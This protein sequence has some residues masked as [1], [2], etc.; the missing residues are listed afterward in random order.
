MNDNGVPIRI[1]TA[2]PVGAS[3]RGRLPPLSGHEDEATRQRAEGQAAPV[4]QSVLR[5]ILDGSIVPGSRT[6]VKGLPA[7]VTPEVVRGGFAHRLGRGASGPLLPHGVGSGPG[8]RDA[9]PAG[10]CSSRTGSAMRG[11]PI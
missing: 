10:S 7:W 5:G 11:W 8:N 1:G 9:R 3:W 6:P 4:E 2:Y